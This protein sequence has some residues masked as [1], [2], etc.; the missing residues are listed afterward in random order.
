MAVSNERPKAWIDHL[1]DDN[2]IEAQVHLLYPD[3][4]RPLGAHAVNSIAITQPDPAEALALLDPES[5][6]DASLLL[7]MNF[8]H[9]EATSN[10]GTEQNPRYTTIHHDV[11][12]LAV[13]TGLGEFEPADILAKHGAL[14][15]GLEL[16]L[17]FYL[18]DKSKTSF[19]PLHPVP[20]ELS[21]LAK[22][23]DLPDKL[24]AFRKGRP[25]EGHNDLKFNALYAQYLIDSA[26]ERNP[27]TVEVP[28]WQQSQANITTIL[29]TANSA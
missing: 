10:K 11:G 27:R 8:R 28:F 21:L 20:S 14:P 18:L 17:S 4:R 2:N 7:W 19:G 22:Q 12:M 1:I 24:D 23:H 16:W 29:K 5:L 9:F 25:C 26:R 3:D 15:P 6:P 13:H